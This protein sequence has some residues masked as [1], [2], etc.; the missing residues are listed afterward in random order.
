M[1]VLFLLPCFLLAAC[2]GAM[3][4]DK[5]DV[6]SEVAFIP[7]NKEQRT[8]AFKVGSIR[9]ERGEPYI[10][11]PYWHWSVPNVEVGFF[12]CN[13]GLKYRL[14]NS[15]AKWNEDEDVFG[16]W[17]GEMGPYIEQPIAQMGYDVVQT[18]MSNFKD[19]K[20]MSRADVLLSVN[21]TN[22]KSNLCYAHSPLMGTS[23]GTSAGT[24]SLTAEWEI[25]DTITDRII[26]HA[27]TGGQAQVDDLVTSGDKLLLMRAV[28]DA[29]A[30]FARTQ[31]LYNVM[32][33]IRTPSD[34]QKSSHKPM[35][36]N[37]GFR[38][39]S[40]HISKNYPAIRPAILAV[41]SDDTYRGTGF[42]INDDGYALTSASVVR[43][44]KN[45]QVTD[46]IGMKHRAQ[47]I[48]TDATRDVA[49]IK[50]DVSDNRFLPVVLDTWTSAGETVY[51]VGTP[52]TTN[53][54]PTLTKGTVSHTR[55]NV[56]TGYTFLQADIHATAEFNGGPLMDE[57]GNVI[58]M[59]TG[60]TMERGE[61][62]FNKFVP[63]DEALASINLTL[64]KTTKNQRH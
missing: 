31:A 36:L 1:K 23:M 44:A 17:I 56:K 53:Y 11:Y 42:F 43:D 16:K 25:Y 18:R 22:I 9:L 40:T 57:M 61:G 41:G 29:A 15:T 6:P 4:L 51:A 20:K 33:D 19:Y 28:Q 58:G 3:P 59:A 54:K 27:T 45:I 39:F 55:Y 37:T 47:V 63:L 62:A 13:L 32:F 21:I 64:I 34:I 30:N 5:P 8:L 60:N 38:M 10:A 35:S 24:M 12:V 46:S 14:T 52:R 49:L 7:K 48:R 2:Q 50:A 26:A